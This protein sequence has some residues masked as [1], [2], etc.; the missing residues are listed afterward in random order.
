MTAFFRR[1]WNRLKGIPC[2]QLCGHPAQTHTVPFCHSPP[3]KSPHGFCALWE[4]DVCGDCWFNLN[5]VKRMAR[6]CKSTRRWHRL[7]AEH[8][9][10]A[11]FNEAKP[12]A[13]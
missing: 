13:V 3:C 5:R 9:R 11:V 2:C 1:F 6:V 4:S 7:P 10:A 8:A 12:H